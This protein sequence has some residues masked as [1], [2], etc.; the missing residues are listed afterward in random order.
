MRL[1]AGIWYLTFLSG[2]LALWGQQYVIST[3]AGGAPPPTPVAA[4][5]ASFSTAGGVAVDTAGNVYFSSADENPTGANIFKVDANG[6]L[7]RVAGNSRPG[8]AGDGGPAT[9]AQLHTPEGLAVDADGNLYIADILNQRIRKV[10]PDGTI[11]TVAGTGVRGYFGDGGPATAARISLGGSLWGADGIGVAVDAAGNLYIADWRNHRIRKVSSDGIITTVAGNGT[12]GASGDGGPAASA[13]LSYPVSVAVDASGNLFISDSGNSRIRKVSP[14]G[15]ITSVAGVRYPAGLAVDSSGNLYIA[16]SGYDRIFKLFASGGGSTFAGTGDTGFS[17]DGGPAAS[18]MLNWPVGV[19]VDASGNVYIADSLNNRIRRVSPDGIITTIAN[20]NAAYN[21]GDG[22]PATSATLSFPHSVAVDGSGNLYFP[23]GASRI[24]KVSAGG[25]ITTLAGN[26]TQGYS[27]DAGPATSAQLSDPIGVAVDA[28]GDVYIADRGNNRIRKV[29]PSGI[30]TTVAGTGK[31]GFSGDAGPATAA[32]LANPRGLA[33]DAAG[34]LYIADHDNGRIRKVSTNGVIATVAG[35]GAQSSISFTGDG[36]PAT[37]AFLNHPAGVAVDGSGNL[38]IA[39]SGYSRIRKVPSSGTI[40]TIAGGGTQGRGDGGPAVNAELSLAAPP[41]G[42]SYDDSS[43]VA[44]D[45]AGSVYISDTGCNCVRKVSPDG[46]ITTIAGNGTGDYSGY[47][48]DGGTATN[49]QLHFPDGLAVDRAGDVYVADVDN[50]AIRVLQPVA[51]AP[52]PNITAAG[53]TNAATALAG[54]IAPNEF[55]SVWGR[56]LGPDSGGYSGPMTT[57]AAGTSVYIG[58]IPA[59]IV[60][61]S[62]AQVNAVVP[63]GIAYRGATT[64][65]VEY[66]GVQ[67]NV[68]TVPVVA[69]SPGIFTQ[70]GGPGQAWV[71]NQDLTF[72]SASNPAARNSYVS[73]WATGQGLVDVPPPDGVQPTGPPFP[74]PLLPV[75]V[76]LGAVKVPDT[77]LAFKGLV[78]SGEI[79]LNVLIPDSAPTGATV[80]LVVAIG[81]A[82]SRTGVTIAI[83]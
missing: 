25:T 4:L 41:M 60:Y 19:A 9:A 50:H 64:I 22:G 75:S 58:G 29:A 20:G 31:Q 16:S 61:S 44:V 23:D 51:A 38:Y 10:S 56:G 18:A 33:V 77:N 48:G 59:A 57:L 47:S 12:S 63:F 40:T 73:F 34:N 62:A 70:G 43:G 5:S 45:G 69:S 30:I 81:G 52:L 71:V 17:G 1:L 53:I 6:V 37:S 24:R 7:T 72:N 15:I 13:Q 21:S 36:G 65:Q 67:G 79:Q 83:K 2:A 8:Y 55:I 39:D 32:A 49:A 78:Y 76:S 27:G 35:G 26:G 66:N 54:A 80:P 14:A 74:I 68:I 42:G 11:T 82:S 28:S 46:I 3:V